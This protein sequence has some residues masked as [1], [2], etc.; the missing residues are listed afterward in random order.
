MCPRLAPLD[1]TLRAVGPGLG[2]SLAVGRGLG[3][4]D[5]GVSR[6]QG[7]LGDH[8]TCD[9]DLAHDEAS[10]QEGFIRPSGALLAWAFGL[11]AF[12]CGQSVASAPCG[13]EGR[14]VWWSQVPASLTPDPPSPP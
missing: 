5:L 7:L 1:L 6:R 13:W 9:Q 11:L 14:P 3:Q 10:C 8:W 4:V 2:G 12:P